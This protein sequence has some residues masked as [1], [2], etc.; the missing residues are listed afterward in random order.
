MAIIA[1]G[2]GLFDMN[3]LVE[4]SG[5]CTHLREISLGL[6]RHFSYF[7][8]D[9]NSRGILP[10]CPTPLKAIEIYSAL[11]CCLFERRKSSIQRLPIDE[12]GPILRFSALLDVKAS[13]EINLS[14]FFKQVT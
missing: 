4:M 1:F 3:G 9:G 12:Q 11:T 14:S 8:K 2:Q 6:L 7:K 5:S 10:G 13:P